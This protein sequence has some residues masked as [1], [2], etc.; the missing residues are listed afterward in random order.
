MSTTTTFH[1]PAPV[2][3]PRAAPLAAWLAEQLILALRALSRRLSAAPAAQAAARQRGRVAEAAAL[4]RH[5]Q[6]LMGA[7]PRFAAD[8]FAAAD[9]HE[10]EE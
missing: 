1:T 3:V 7:D 4:R 10:R 2:R 9:R 5:A 6:Q 8:L